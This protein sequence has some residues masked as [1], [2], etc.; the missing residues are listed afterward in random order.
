MYI[1]QTSLYI[2]TNGTSTLVLWHRPQYIWLHH[3]PGLRISDQTWFTYLRPNPFLSPSPVPTHVVHWFT[4]VTVSGIF[5][6]STWYD[7]T[8]FSRC[9]RCTDLS[10]FIYPGTTYIPTD[11]FSFVTEGLCQ[12]FITRTV[13]RLPSV[14]KRSKRL[15]SSYPL[16][17][18]DVALP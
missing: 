3:R 8:T 9:K 15:W 6:C 5:L 13:S 17:D 10:P 11:S 14:D 1:P 2:H 18:T 4:R 12:N 7:I 16:Q